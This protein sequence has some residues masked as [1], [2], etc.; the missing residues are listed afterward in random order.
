MPLPS[1]GLSEPLLKTP[2]QRELW[3]AWR[4][5]WLMAWERQRRLQDK[6]NYSQEMEKLQD[7]DF[8][9]WRKRVRHLPGAGRRSLPVW[10]YTRWRWMYAV[11][12]A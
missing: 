4:N 6:Y 8:E 5:T 10:S 1:R 11:L 3:D 2:Q 9:E 7:F 12:I